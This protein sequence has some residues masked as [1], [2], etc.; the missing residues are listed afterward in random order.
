MLTPHGNARFL[1]QANHAVRSAGAHQRIAQCQTADIVGVEAVDILG[2]IDRVNHHALVD[3]VRKRHLHKDPV[4]AFV[5]VE[6]FDQCDQ[7]RLG[8]GVGQIVADGKETAFV[9]GQPLVSY[10]N[11]RRGIVA[12]QHDGQSRTA[13]TARHHTIG[14][15]AHFPL[16]V[17]G[18][19]LAVNDPGGRAGGCGGDGRRHAVRSV[20]GWY[21]FNYSRR[22]APRLSPIP[23]VYKSVL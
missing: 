6:A 20:G 12:D 5:G 4:D 11:V 9:A 16:H 18:D 10:I 17:R 21:W 3:L 13:Q 15:F 19:G 22:A 14:R 1:E 2:G 7:F 23:P 8:S